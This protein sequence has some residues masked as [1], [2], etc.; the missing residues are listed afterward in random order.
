MR[1][2]KYRCSKCK[3]NNLELIN[4]G[5]SNSC[6]LMWYKL[7]CKDCGLLQDKEFC[8]YDLPLKIK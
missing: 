4:I 3:S 2:T 6:S 5:C 8:E 7:K 1:R